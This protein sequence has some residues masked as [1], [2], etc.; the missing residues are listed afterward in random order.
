MNVSTVK[1]LWSAYGAAWGWPPVSMTREQD[2]ADVAHHEAEIATR[3]SFNYA[4]VDGRCA[5]GSGSANEAQ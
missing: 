2:R 3:Q 4:L 5:G 1:R